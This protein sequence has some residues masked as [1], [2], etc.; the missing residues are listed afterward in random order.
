MKYKKNCPTCDSVACA[1]NEEGHCIAL[2]ECFSDKKCP[3]FKTKKQAKKERDYC[4]IRMA[5][6]AIRRIKTC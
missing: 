2:V 5:E 3:F 4:E 1:A 6:L